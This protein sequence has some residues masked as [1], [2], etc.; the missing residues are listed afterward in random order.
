MPSID[1]KSARKLLEDTFPGAESALLQRDPPRI[2]EKA[3]KACDTVFE[4]PTKAYR[5]VLLGCT[6]ARIQDSSSE[7]HQPYVEQGPNA[8]SGRSLDEKVINPFLQSKRIPCSKGPYLSVFRRSVKLDETT[9]SGLRDKTG[10]DA[11]LEALGFLDALDA[12]GAKEFLRYQLYKFAV[13]RESANILLYRLPRMSLQQYDVLISGL[14][15]TASGGLFP[16]LLAVAMF[17]SI[18]DFFALDWVVAWQGINV[19][20]AASGAGGDITIRKDGKTLLAVEVTERLVD[21][22]RV[23]GTFNTK[24]ASAGIEDYLFFLG[25][26]GATSDAK[27]QAQQYFAQGYEVNF[28]NIKEWI[29]MLLATMGKSGREI[30]NGHLTEL[31][32][33]ADAPQALKVNW[34]QQIEALVAV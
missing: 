18:K 2:D 25:T 20:D 13:L 31:L 34:N 11:L 1:Y 4:S 15:A 7:I 22:N 12:T 14:L 33:G 30:F 9:R 29:L 32:A 28:V 19:A 24:I 21:K 27:L 6:V 16:V 10:Y 26:P 3:R 5:E 17:N 23:V 8:F